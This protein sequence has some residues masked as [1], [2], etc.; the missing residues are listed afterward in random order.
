[1]K[2]YLILSIYICKCI[3]SL[4]AQ[5]YDNNWI[6]G[7][8]YE[9]KLPFYFTMARQW[10]FS[11]VG[12]VLTQRDSLPIEA[13]YLQTLSDKQGKI[14]FYTNGNSIFSAIDD[15]TME[16]C[17]NLNQGSYWEVEPGPEWPS[18]QPLHSFNAVPDKYEE[19]TYYLLHSFG[20]IKFELGYYL[21]NHGY[22]KKLQITKVDMSKNGGKGRVIYN[23]KVIDNTYCNWNIQCCQHGNGKDWWIALKNLDANL[24]T[25]LL[26]RRD[27]IIAKV[28]NPVP[29]YK[30]KGYDKYEEFAGEQCMPEFSPD[31]S[32][33]IDKYGDRAVRLFDFDRCS[34]LLTLRDTM[35]V[36]P[37]TFHYTH[38]GSPIEIERAYTINNVV[39]PFCFSPDSKLLYRFSFSGIEQYELNAKPLSSSKV[40]I[41]GPIPE[42]DPL[43]GTALPLNESR[44]GEWA[45]NGPDGKIYGFYIFENHVINKPNVKGLG[46][47]LCAQYKCLGQVMYGF[48]PWYPNYRMGAL[49]GSACD[50]IVSSV[51]ATDVKN[52]SIKAYPNPSR[53]DI[54]VEISMPEYGNDA[55]AV[56]VITDMQGREIYKESYEP[57]SY[58][59][60]IDKGTLATG[61]YLATLM[62]RG[63]AM[64]S[65]KLVVLE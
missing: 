54:Q 4:Y 48:A 42:Y 64:K 51:S 7:E 26:L 13:R 18:S 44:S 10:K 58:I 30:Y 15:I 65:V 37:D 22:S 23:G 55:K 32:M 59:K 56:L 53:G 2:K 62:V 36:Q 60:T 6:I 47:D 21:I 14:Q 35:F 45:C 41:S 31:G 12:L 40:Q 16:N 57:Y 49:K 9:Y 38:N 33:M 61:T 24:Y 27:S 11:D 8:G 1:M 29:E 25:M 39:R 50:T 52:Y 43:K 5:K 20:Q 19:N 63:N 17:K 28:E 3:S 34:G 46:C